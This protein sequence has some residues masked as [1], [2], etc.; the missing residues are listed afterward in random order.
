VI[1]HDINIR[2]IT[3]VSVF[4]VLINTRKGFVAATICACQ[5]I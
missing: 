5:T 3:S 1:V 4:I 2:K